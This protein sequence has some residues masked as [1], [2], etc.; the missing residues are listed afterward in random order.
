[1]GPKTLHSTIEA[2]IMAATMRAIFMMAMI[3][4]RLGAVAVTPA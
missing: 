1:M 2:R 4:S 3:L